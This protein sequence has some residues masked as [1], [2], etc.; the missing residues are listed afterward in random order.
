MA[1]LHFHIA[2]SRASQTGPNAKVPDMVAEGAE[3]EGEKKREGN[4]MRKE[5]RGREKER[6]EVRGM[7]VEEVGWREQVDWVCVWA[8]RW[9]SII[10]GKRMG[11]WPLKSI[12]GKGVFTVN[13]N[14]CVC[15]TAR[16]TLDKPTAVNYE[17]ACSEGDRL[18]NM[19]SWRS[20]QS[21]CNTSVRPPLHLEWQGLT[22]VSITSTGQAT[23]QSLLGKDPKNCSLTH[24]EI[25]FS[26]W[27]QWAEVSAILTS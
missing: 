17:L 5:A 16:A 10:Q 26:I 21:P 22:W 7:G 27:R 14:I 25:N 19:Q 8:F 12:H 11:S 1:T 15:A 13:I 23:G 9:V 20:A 3:R 2:S 6:E 18:V 24:T 4:W